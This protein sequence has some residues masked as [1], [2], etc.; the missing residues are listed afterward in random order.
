MRIEWM[1]GPNRC[2]TL[3]RYVLIQ[4]TG[5]TL[6]TRSSVITSFT[7]TVSSNGFLRPIA[8]APYASSNS[9]P[10]AYKRLPI[11]PNNPNAVRIISRTWLRLICRYGSM[12]SC[13]S[14]PRS[15]GYQQFSTGITDSKVWFFLPLYLSFVASFGRSY[16]PYVAL[17]RRLSTRNGS[18]CQEVARN[19]LYG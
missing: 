13:N 3:V 2:W 9:T 18:P 4:L 5:L 17:T 14:A 12:R 11:T 10:R 19:K 8:S 15:L 16:P 7:V 1:T 6:F